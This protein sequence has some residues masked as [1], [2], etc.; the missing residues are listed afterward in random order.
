V[1]KRITENNLSKFLYF[2]EAEHWVL[3]GLL[4]ITFLVGSIIFFIGIICLIVLFPISLIP[5]G[6][7]VGA[8]L[9]RYTYKVIKEF[10]EWTR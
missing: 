1:S 9:S 10:G 7:I 6:I 4:T 5:I 8:L 2:L 3:Y